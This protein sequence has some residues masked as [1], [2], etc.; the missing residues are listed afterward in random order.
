[1]AWCGFA[2]S[3]LCR[4]AS[5]LPQRTRCGLLVTTRCCPDQNEI[6]MCQKEKFSGLVGVRLPDQN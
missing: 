4:P 3:A 6:H 5:P 1:M 2:S